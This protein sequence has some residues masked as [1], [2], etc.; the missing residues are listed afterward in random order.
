MWRRA[1]GVREGSAAVI[2]PGRHWPGWA[3]SRRWGSSLNECLG[4]ER[5]AERPRLIGWV[6]AVDDLRA[7]IA[8]CPIAIRLPAHCASRPRPLLPR[9]SVL[10]LR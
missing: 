2:Q 9:R 3:Q 6:A 8:A 10:I 7:A 5:L 4:H 1:D